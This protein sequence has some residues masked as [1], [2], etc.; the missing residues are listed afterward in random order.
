MESLVIALAILGVVGGSAGLAAV[1]IFQNLLYICGPNE[2]LVFS[3][4][5]EGGKGYRAVKGGRGWRIPM[6]ETVDRMDL[7]NMIIDVSVQNAY[8]DGGIPLN[9]Q[10]VANVKIAGHEPA[11]SFAVERLL[12]KSQ[13]D[14]SRIAKEVLEGTLRGVL[15]RLT[16]EMVNEDKISFAEKLQDEAERDLAHL[17]LVLDT[18]KIQNVH[19]ERGYLDSIGRR[20][21]AEVMKKARIAEAEAKSRALQR[22]GENRTRARIK[23]IEATAAIAQ[24]KNE[25]RIGDARSKAKALIAEAEGQ[26][27]AQVV[28]A[29]AS[30]E[31]EQAR[32]ERVRLQLEADVLQPAQAQ[33]AAGIAEAQGRASRILEQGRATTK[34]LEEMVAVWKMAGEDARDIFLMQKYQTVLGALVDTIGTVKVDRITML[35]SGGGSGTASQAVRLVEELKGAI[36]VD[37]PKMLTDVT[38][39]A[40]S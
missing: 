4:T 15:S 10:G 34:V 27:S 25:R 20:Q 11:L 16:P 38:R 40:D 37:L 6:F 3:G 35:P 39:R 23:E 13:A 36:G 7:S 14:I 28:R 33:M 9:I 29:E 2:V 21:S 5:G 12:G 30:I 17:G 32:V 31:A 1:R 26:V 19:D 22:D 18:M 24:A 8:S